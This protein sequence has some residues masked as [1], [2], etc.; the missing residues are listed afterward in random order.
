MSWRRKGWVRFKVVCFDIDPSRVTGGLCV[1]RFLRLAAF[2]LGGWLLQM[3][4]R[5]GQVR[6]V[7]GRN[8]ARG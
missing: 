4:G 3:A 7:L 5:P 1:R 8:H 6:A 2:A